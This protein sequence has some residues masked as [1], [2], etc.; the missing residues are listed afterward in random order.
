MRE[1][2]IRTNWNM[3]L[4]TVNNG[5]ELSSI[6]DWALTDQDL[7][8]LGILHEIGFHR[9]K[10]EQLLTDCNFHTECSLLKEEN[11]SDYTTL[12]ADEMYDLEVRKHV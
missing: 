7:L 5:E 8:V 11:Y 2:L 1:E 3:A 4:A 6:I 9:E 12:I 10:I